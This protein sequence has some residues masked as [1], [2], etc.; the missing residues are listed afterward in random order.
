[1]EID[2]GATAWV[3]VATALVLFMTPGLAFF[4]A[5]MVRRKNVLGTMM[6][7]FILMAVVTV[8]WAVV[9][10]SLAFGVGAAVSVGGP[11]GFIGIIVPQLVRLLVG[12]DHRIVLPASALFGAAFLIVAAP[13]IA[14]AVTEPISYFGRAAAVS[15]FNPAVA[16]DASGGS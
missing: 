1:M 3:L 2:S 4:Y 10:Y 9:G 6:H 5:G 12:A 13:M 11:I 16:A 7:S 14:V 8:I 15:T